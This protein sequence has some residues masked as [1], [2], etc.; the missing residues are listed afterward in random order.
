MTEKELEVNHGCSFRVRHIAAVLLLLLL[1]LLLLMADTLGSQ[2][3]FKLLTVSVLV[4]ER[5]CVVL[6]HAALLAPLYFQA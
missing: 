1:L 3:L 6:I 5:T 4:N 2:F